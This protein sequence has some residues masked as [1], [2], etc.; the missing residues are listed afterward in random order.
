MP[1]EPLGM[2]M[3][4]LAIDRAES[5]ARDGITPQTDMSQPIGLSRRN[6]AR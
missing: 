1:G 6:S 3:Q 4:R 5:R 2:R